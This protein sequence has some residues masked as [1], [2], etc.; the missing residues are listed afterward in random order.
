MATPGT[1]CTTSARVANMPCLRTI[2][3]GTVIAVP[4][5]HG[6]SLAG[7]EGIAAQWAAHA[8]DARARA[9]EIVA[10]QSAT[11]DGAR[12]REM[13]ARWD[14]A[15]RLLYTMRFLVPHDRK[16]CYSSMQSIQAAMDKVS[17]RGHYWAKGHYTQPTN[18][19]GLGHFDVAR[20]LR[21]GWHHK[22]LRAATCADGATSASARASTRW[23]NSSGR[24]PA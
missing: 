19:G 18:E 1:Q 20:H 17:S 11:K 22:G 10:R 15:A 9:V 23:S 5:W 6:V 4:K 3:G 24:A 12:A 2:A 14:I 8:A 16:L 7:E 21:S 13:Q